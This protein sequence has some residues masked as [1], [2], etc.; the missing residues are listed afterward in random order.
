MPSYPAYSLKFM[1]KLFAAWIAML[2][3]R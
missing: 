3:R 1:A 2:L